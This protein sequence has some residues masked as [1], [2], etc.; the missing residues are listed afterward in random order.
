MVFLPPVPATKFIRGLKESGF[1]GYVATLSINGIPAA[2]KGIGDKSRGLALPRVL[3]RPT[4][5]SNPLAAEFMK[6]MKEGGNDEPTAGHFRS[7][8]HRTHRG[9]STETRRSQHQS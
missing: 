1:T 9:R 7:V 8:C 2:I 3:P 6:V 5:K 4:D